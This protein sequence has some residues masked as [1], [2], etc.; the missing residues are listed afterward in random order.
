MSEGQRCSVVEHTGGPPA[1]QRPPY[2]NMKAGIACAS[3]DQLRQI[4][5]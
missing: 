3:S 2:D 5:L 1:E 4:K